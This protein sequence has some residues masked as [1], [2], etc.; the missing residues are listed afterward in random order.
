M[1]ALILV[2]FFGQPPADPF[3]KWEKEVTAI[4]KRHKDSPPKKGGVV[5]AGSSTIRLWD[6]KKSFPDWDAANCGFGGNQV[7]D[8]THF[9]ARLIVPL[10]PRAVVFYA[11]DNDLNAKR[12]PEQVLDDFRAFTKAVHGKL[13]ACKIYFLS[14][15]PSVARWAQYE[16]QSKAN[17][18]VKVEVA[19][20]DRVVYV[21][22]V[23]PLLGPNGKPPADLFVKDGLHFSEKGYAL[24]TA[25]VK[26]AVR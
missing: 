22:I 8:N 12:T 14:I 10:E 3:A 26:K 25:E 20:S 4:E 5:F 16:T 21:D 17:T 2:T 6:V 9:A 24:V 11:G 15:K 23:T 7:R 19:K 13:P 18:L 1:T